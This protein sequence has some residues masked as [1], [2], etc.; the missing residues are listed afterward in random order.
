MMG[1]VELRIQE[2]KID[3]RRRTVADLRLAIQQLKENH[4]QNFEKL[5]QQLYPST[6]DY[7]PIERTPPPETP[8]P[9]P[10]AEWD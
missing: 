3:T 6:V 1:K 9:P 7:H 5:R 4:H 2:I 10:A 8:P